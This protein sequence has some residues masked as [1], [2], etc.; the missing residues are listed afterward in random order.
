[1]SRGMDRI[2]GFLPLATRTRIMQ[3]GNEARQEHLKKAQDWDEDTTK[4]QAPLPLRAATYDVSRYAIFDAQPGELLQP[5]ERNI[6]SA[7]MI[8]SPQ[9]NFCYG[10]NI[11]PKGATLEL[12][13]GNRTSE[14]FFDGEVMVP[15]LYMHRPQHYKRLKVW[16]SL[17]PAEMLS[18]RQGI[19]RATGTVLIGGLG[20]GWLLRKVA[21]KKSVKKIIVVE[22][23]QEL[24]DW[25]GNDLCARVAKE[26]DTEVEVICDDVYNQIGKHGKDV[27]HLID[28]EE[29]YPGYLTRDQ[30]KVANSVDHFWAWGIFADDR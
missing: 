15:T 20:L 28:I 16:M 13:Q 12:F 2:W 23:S 5:P 30:R 19:R 29:S 25:Y 18:Q 3:Q 1:M 11:L 7:R 10:H 26:T 27:R 17:T 6:E 4:F 14:V 9:R 22:I 21:E 8:W 24:L